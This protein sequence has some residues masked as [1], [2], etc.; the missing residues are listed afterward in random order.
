MAIIDRL[1]DAT[2][3]N[4]NN[5]QQTNKS[6]EKL[7]LKIDDLCIFRGVGGCTVSVHLNSELVYNYGSGYNRD[8]NNK[9]LSIMIMI[10]TDMDGILIKKR[11]IYGIREAQLEEYH[12]YKS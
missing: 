1:I 6:I 2:T 5:N 9:T 7:N 12:I 11:I 4:E 10:I 8:I 3:N